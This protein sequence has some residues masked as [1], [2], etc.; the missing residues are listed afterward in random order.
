MKDLNSVADEILD[1]DER[2]TPVTDINRS[3]PAVVDEFSWPVLMTST[4][5]WFKR[6]PEQPPVSNVVTRMIASESKS[7]KGE[8]IKEV[9]KAKES[10]APAFWPPETPDLADLGKLSLPASATGGRQLW[11][12][13]ESGVSFT[14][15][16]DFIVNY[17]Y[18]MFHFITSDEPS[19]IAAFA[20]A[21]IKLCGE[22]GG[23]VVNDKRFKMRPIDV[24]RIGNLISTVSATGMAPERL[25]K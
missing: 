14:I 13:S 23:V 6:T 3:L 8:A 18:P 12:T 4:H 2:W 9:K 11:H 16:P 24:E 1:T 17:N 22:E 7:L 19:L 10:G 21:M 5:S 15:R 25:V 20:S